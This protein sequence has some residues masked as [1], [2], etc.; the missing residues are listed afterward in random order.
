[1]TEVVVTAIV[2]ARSLT[3]HGRRCLARLVELDGVETIFVP[4]EPV[5]VP[6]GV[7]C[8]AS[9][10]VPVGS[11]RQ[12]ALASAQGAFVAL[13]DDDA[14]PHRAW[15]EHV[16]AAFAADPGVAAVCGPTLT[17]R[18]DAPLEQLGG[19]VYASPLVAGPHRWRFA[20]RPPRDV[21]DAPSANL[22]LRREVAVALRLDSEFH[23]GEDSI[24]C[25]R[26][27][28]S[29][30]RIRYVPG[31]VVFHSR[32][33]LWRPHLRQ[34]W[35]FGRRRGTFARRFGGNSRRAAY[36]APSLLVLGAGG[37]WLLPGRGRDLWA[38]GLALYAVAAVAAGADGDPRAWA[39][40]S[41]GVPAT[42]AVYGVGFLLGLAGVP[43]PE[44]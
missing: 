25:D 6:D 29:G 9:G 40:V 30:G 21:D 19:R 22:V 12:L 4:D 37:G 32:R 13:I 36:F 35:R 43:L 14:Y 2:P 3:A 31:A 10:P 44:D 23:P 5:E 18:D 20:P 1:M 26:I 8:V 17:P 28:R 15:L 24:V 7:R 33:P 11:K 38:A 42:H 41:A 39:R 34:V 16:L 27:L